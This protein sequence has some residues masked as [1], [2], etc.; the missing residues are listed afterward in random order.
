[1]AVNCP[2]ANILLERCEEG[3]GDEVS[4]AL[5]V[6]APASSSLFLVWA[7]NVVDVLTPEDPNAKFIRKWRGN[8]INRLL[9]KHLE[10]MS[11]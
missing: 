8:Q 6:T 2:A 7:Q 5:C 1:M 10:S 9:Q 3:A 11:G 4:L